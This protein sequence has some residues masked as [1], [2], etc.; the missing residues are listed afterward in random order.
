[1]ARLRSQN[2]CVV[3]APSDMREDTKVLRYQGERA[4]NAIVNR[5]T[6]KREARDFAH[7]VS[8]FYGGSLEYLESRIFPSSTYH[9]KLVHHPLS[10]SGVIVRLKLGTDRT[11]ESLGHELLHIALPMRG[12]PMPETAF[13]PDCLVPYSLHLMRMQ[14]IA[15]NLIEHELIY[16]DFLHLGFSCSAFISEL[17]KPPDY[18][19]VSLAALYSSHVEAVEF[20]WW[21]LE[22]LRHWLSARHGLGTTMDLYADRA[23]FWGSRIYPALKEAALR[24]RAMIES[25]EMMERE[26]YPG[27]ANRLLRTMKLPE[28]SN[29]VTMMAGDKSG[30]LIVRRDFADP[31]YAS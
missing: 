7:G 23:L 30:P 17:P 18:E 25:G 10:L 6:G 2:A 12:Y 4:R 27:Y 15:S 29:W 21:C 13:V 9:I 8:T 16:E 11:I 1:M 5:L 3:E 22:Y 14:S 26:S 20:P 31:L 19:T 24:L 28:Y